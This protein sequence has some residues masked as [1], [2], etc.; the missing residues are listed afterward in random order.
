MVK[1]P[2]SA[3]DRD[4]VVTDLAASELKT[5]ALDVNG[6]KC[7]GCVK[8]V[9]RQ[10]EQNSGVVSACVNLI[11]QVAV[12]EYEAKAIAP[13]DLAEKL[14]KTGFPSQ[15]RQSDRSIYQIAAADRHKRQQEAQQRTR[16]LITATILLV[17]SQY[18]SSTSPRLARYSRPEQYLG[19]FWTG[20]SGFISSRAI[21]HP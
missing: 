12:V 20:N 18:R 16:Q 4:L 6:M 15:L 9:E 1:S 2:P 11:T 21:A 13:E 7:A 10:L 17:F 8:A 5:V 14:T 19:A 3:E